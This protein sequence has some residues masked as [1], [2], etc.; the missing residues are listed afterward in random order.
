MDGRRSGRVL[1]LLENCPYSVDGRVK[2]EARTLTGAG[3][4]VRVICPR[5]EGGRFREEYDGVIAYQYPPSPSVS[6]A[7][8]YVVEWGY[9]LLVAGLISLYVWARHG[10]D[11]VHAHNPPDL[12]FLLGGFYRLFGKRFVFDHHDLVPE[13]YRARSGAGTSALVVRALTLFERW[14]CRTADHVVATN[15]SYAGLEQQRC[16]VPEE[17]ITVVRNGPDASK[18]K[19]D[20]GRRPAAND[21]ELV[22][23]YVGVV[24][25]QDGVDHL[26]GAL[27]HLAEGSDVPPWRCVIVGSGDALD[28][29]RRLA[30]EAGLSQRISFTGWVGQSE[31]MDHLNRADVCVAPEPSNGLNDHSTI[32]KIME[33]MAMARPVVAFDLREHRRSA[34]EAALYARPNDEADFARQV[35]TL[36]RDPPLRERLGRIGR[37]RIETQLSWQ[38]QAPHLLKAYQSLDEEGRL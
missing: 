13:L 15:L 33:Y 16:G 17:R 10:I 30:E 5:P 8:G 28:G 25:L 20:P 27:K 21:E 4:R 26:V 31:V 1:M 23:V 14:S 9:A 24:N 35:L 18:F 29:V 32:I 11:V 19:P 22:I 3:Y 12:F 34:G 37:E 6:G 38:H 2:R 7:L 36:F